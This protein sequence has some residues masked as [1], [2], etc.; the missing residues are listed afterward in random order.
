MCRHTGYRRRMR[1]WGA[2]LW[3]RVRFE[4]PLRGVV[5]R[6]LA[7]RAPQPWWM[8]RRALHVVSVDVDATAGVAAIWIEWRPTSPWTRE[9]IALLERF[10]GR[11]RYAGGGS[12]PGDDDVDVD[13]LHVR[14]GPGVLS[15]TRRL[16]PP[17]SLTA[18]PWISC[19]QVRLGRAVDHVRIGARRVESPEEGKLIAV[20]TSAHDN[21]RDRP[22]IVA[23]ARD[24]A[25]LS[26]MG[27]HD[28]LDSHT[29]ARIRREM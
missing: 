14:V 26:R 6:V 9:H 10:G 16:D 7:G 1:A 11:W 3:A 8:P 15:L 27:L 28:S 19:V 20:W 18:A 22:L 5:R 17:R 23:L 2:A 29:W 13:V 21:R 24:G 4:T 12:G 25:E